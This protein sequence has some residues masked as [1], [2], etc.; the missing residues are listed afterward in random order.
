MQSRQGILKGL[1]VLAV[2]DDLDAREILKSV[3]PYF[4]AFPTVVP[5]ARDALAILKQAAPDLVI[6]DMLL[7][8]SDGL[9]MLRQARKTG[10][11]VPFIAISGKDFDATT[12]E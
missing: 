11:Q 4:G 3:V 12:L 1:H 2:D 5:T 8:T 7:G 10:S 9:T 6:T